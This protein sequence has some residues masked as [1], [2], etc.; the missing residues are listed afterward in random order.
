MAF[1]YSAHSKMHSEK[2]FFR[3]FPPPEIMLMPSVGLDI[4]DHT[5]RFIELKTKAGKIEI[6]RHG[7][8]TIPDSTL[9]LGEIKDAAA[10]KTALSALAKENDLSFVRMS[11]PEE[12]AY[13]FRTEVPLL[14]PEETKEN[15][16]FQ[17]EEHVPIGAGDAVFDYVVANP[18]FGK[19]G[20]AMRE[21]VVSVFPREFIEGYVDVLAGAG[22]TPLSFEMEASAIARSLVPVNNLKTYMIVDFGYKRTGII[23]VSRGAVHLSTTVD[24]GGEA[25]TEAIEKKLSITRDEAEAL[26]REG[27]FSR[28][29]RYREMF[30][31]LLDAITSLKDQVNKLFVY[32]HNHPDKKDATPPPIERIILTGGD[33][34][35]EG[36]SDHFALAMRV[37]AE[38]GNVWSNILRT[39]EEVPSISF[40]ESLSYAVAIG[41]AMRDL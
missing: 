40:S 21:V 7:E 29:G 34:N 23:I 24:I 14:S 33:A 1:G 10:L 6:G 4:S 17:L 19:I 5:A 18:L 13:L 26:K 25:L 30:P 27:A 39:N 32:W 22:L 20:G 35:L 15:I 16:A 41:L 12:K 8:K 38:V 28:N 36:L 9:S 11:L 3:V 37:P 31:L 2:P